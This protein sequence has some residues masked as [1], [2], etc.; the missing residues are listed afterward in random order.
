MRQTPEKMDEIVAGCDPEDQNLPLRLK[1]K[2][3]GNTFRISRCVPSDEDDVEII[4][5]GRQIVDRRSL[6]QDSILEFFKSI[7]DGEVI[8]MFYTYFFCFR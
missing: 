1:R 7:A 2:K 6:V 4:H 5:L 8:V 3:G